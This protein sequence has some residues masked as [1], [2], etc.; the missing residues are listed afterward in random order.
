MLNEERVKVDDSSETKYQRKRLVEDRMWYSLAPSVLARYPYDPPFFLVSSSGPAAEHQ[1]F[2][3]GLYRKTEEKREGRS[4]YAQEY[5][6]QYKE[7]TMRKVFSALFVDGGHNKVPELFIDQGVWM[8]QD[9]Y[10]NVLLRAVTK[11]HTP[12]AVKWQYH[13][14]DEWHD[15]QEITVTGLG[16]K[17]ADC[18][19]TITLSE[20]VVRE[21]YNGIM[22]PGVAGVYRADGTYCTGRPV[23]K[24]E[25]GEFIL[26][27]SGGNW[28]VSAG[29]HNFWDTLW[30]GSAP[31]LCPADPRAARNEKQG[32]RNWRYAPKIQGWMRKYECDGI[33]LKCNKHGY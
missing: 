22:Y 13:S 23:L 25:G 5:D 4:V 20:D 1:S 29:V 6:K 7:G 21:D 12:V 17:P 28:K 19:I 32:V 11:S 2:M 27:S 16:E 18:E 14:R 3:F 33:S 31:S 10:D 30:S 24:H 26:Y 9:V 8:I 15:D